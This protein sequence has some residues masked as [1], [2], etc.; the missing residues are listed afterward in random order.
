MSENRVWNG[1]EE[2]HSENLDFFTLPSVDSG[3]QEYHMI[4]YKPISQIIPGGAVEFSLTAPTFVDLNRSRLRLKIRLENG[5]GTEIGLADLTKNPTEGETLDS[6]MEVGPVNSLFYSMWS[7]VDFTLNTLNTTTSLSTNGFAYKNYIDLLTSK[8]SHMHRTVLFIPDSS[9]GPDARS[10]YQYRN[11]PGYGYNA[12]LTERTEFLNGSNKF[13]MEGPLGIDICDQKRLLIHNVPIS[14][15]YFPN[16]SLF[17]LMSPNDEKRFRAVVLDAT[18]LLCQVTVNPAVV[19]GVASKLKSGDQALYPITRSIF[20]TYTIA[21]GSSNATFDSVFTGDCPE[22]LIVALVSSNGFSGSLS[23]NPYNLQHFNCNSISFSYNGVSVPGRPLTP[24]FATTV[25]KSDFMEA[26]ARL[27]KR[28]PEMNI[29]QEQFLNGC[30][31]FHFDLT[32]NSDPGIVPLSKSGHTRLEISF[33]SE[34]EKSVNVLIY[35]KKTA[36]IKIDE[37]RNVRIEE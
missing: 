14:I 20:K 10:P 32:D 9:K 12:A 26:Y 5:D 36:L 22:S 1:S 23:E 33:R 27:L 30:T 13:T 2:G 24:H 6:S 16:N 8:P 17:Y 31:L 34:L 7:Q 37:A 25:E 21:Q 19:L 3:I 18:L 4:E 15:K 28:N 29:S 11:D 35:A